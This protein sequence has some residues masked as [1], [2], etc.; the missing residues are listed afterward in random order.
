MEVAEVEVVTQL[1]AQAG[2][3]A[4][5]R[6]ALAAAELVLPG[7]PIQ[8]AVAAALVVLRRP[9][10]MV[11]LALSSFPF[12]LQTTLALRLDRQR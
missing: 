1:V 12:L 4:A 6:A 2:L 7:L 11:G 9:L 8:E 5:E 3:V 10:E